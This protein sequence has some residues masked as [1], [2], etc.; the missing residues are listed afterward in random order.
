MDM[1]TWQKEIKK[2]GIAILL[3]VGIMGLYGC[4]NDSS[5]AMQTKEVQEE[6]TQG[7]E[8]ALASSYKEGGEE[9]DV[10][11]QGDYITPEDVTEEDALAKTSEAVADD[12]NQKNTK[13]SSSNQTTNSKKQNTKT[14]TASSHV[15]KK[16]NSSREEEYSRDDSNV[17]SNSE[18]LTNSNNQNNSTAEDK[19]NPANSQNTTGSQSKES[20]CSL[21]IECK[22]VLSHKDKLKKNKQSLIPEKGIIYSN[23]STVFSEGESVFDILLRETKNNKIQMEY[24]N[25]PGFQSNYVEGIANLYEFDC[26]ETSGW[27]YL[28]NGLSPNYGCNR[29][30]VKDGDEIIWRYTCE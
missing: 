26:G 17:S 12:M 8:D 6:G 22:D 13:Q 28:V 18:K 10:E 3:F 19:Q 2:I 16:K 23:P 7:G 11:Y 29:Y 25:T 4:Q 30:T 5:D 21:T 14:D 20:H 27:K 24:N 15:D 9:Q 1:Q